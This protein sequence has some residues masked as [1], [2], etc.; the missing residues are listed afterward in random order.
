MFNKKRKEIYKGFSFYIKKFKLP[1]CTLGFV[2]ICIIILGLI[3]P[4]FYKYFIDDV[5]VAKNIRPLKW[6]CICYIGVFIVE[7]I[8]T[9]LERKMSNKINNRFSFSLRRRIWKRYMSLSMSEIDKGRI[10]DLKMRVDDD[11]EQFNKYIE[12]QIIEYI[13][14]VI[15]SLVNLAILFYINRS[16]AFA[17]I[18]IVPVTFYLGSLT[19]KLLKKYAYKLRIVNQENAAW[20]YDAFERW[21]EIKSL[22]IEK[23]MCREFAAARHKT[24]ILRR[25]ALLVSFISG[26]FTYAKDN[27]IKTI[28][29][30][31]IG[32]FFILRDNFTIGKLLIFVQYYN[33]LFDYLDKI[34]Q[35]NMEMIGNVPAYERI[36]EV[37]KDKPK[38][39][40]G[41]NKKTPVFTGKIK[42]QNLYFKYNKLQDFVLKDI[43]LN[44]KKGEYIAVA[45]RSGCGK[46]TLLKL[47]L[48]LYAPT[49]G[50]I[51]F[52]ETDIKNITEDSYFYRNV[53]VVMQDPI[54]FNT[55]IKENLLLA[56]SRA[57]EFEMSSACRRAGILED[58]MKMPEKFDTVIGENGSK[59]SGGQRQRLAT[60]RVLLG[61]YKIIILD[62]ATSSLDQQCE[63]IIKAQIEE[64]AGSRTLIVVAH[65]LSTIINADR[66]VVLDKGRIAA[67]GKHEELLGKCRA[68]DI[69]LQ[70]EYEKTAN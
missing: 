30:Y 34:N 36:K 70:H 65:K 31:L 27:F 54:M 39:E 2:K 51:F 49:S 23:K 59:L 55:T 50:S 15:F 33:M 32:A 69:L 43:N 46:S 64:M 1:L 7:S 18:L 14:A 41:S 9:F 63:N 28:F 57:S 20:L 68:Y 60:A 3:T 44:I 26:S 62:E 52:D 12:T 5:L 19:G 6:I 11:V 16:L 21:K 17:A 38:D 4:L 37:L 66:I 48:N 13:L 40:R 53:G 10:S 35:S 61:D 29:I 45:G 67:I 25:K 58:I 56:K 8:L 22:N 24:A 42:I 47:L